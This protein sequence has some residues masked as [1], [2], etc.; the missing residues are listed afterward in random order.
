MCVGNQRRIL[1]LN[2]SGEPETKVKQR[3]SRQFVLLSLIEN[4]RTEQARHALRLGRRFGQ[5]TIQ[6]RLIDQC[7]PDCSGIARRLTLARQPYRSLAPP[8]PIVG[9]RSVFIYL[10]AD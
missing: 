5:A 7:E 8:L 2:D 9:A 6:I 3:Q 4:A 1:A 10:R